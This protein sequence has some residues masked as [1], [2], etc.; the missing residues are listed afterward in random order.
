[1]LGMLSGSCFAEWTEV[2]H[3]PG[4]ESQQDFDKDKH[5]Q[6]MISDLLL[7]APNLL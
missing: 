6:P 4:S 3:C 5:C 7:A 1:M 2:F